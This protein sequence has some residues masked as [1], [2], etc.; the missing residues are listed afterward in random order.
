MTT[1]AQ[2]ILAIFGL[3]GVGYLAAR[4]RLLSEQVGDALAEFVFTLAIPVLL[5]RTLAK[6]DFG[7]LSPWPLWLTY[8][9]GVALTWLAA[10]V[11]IRRVFGRDARSGVVAGVSASFSNTVLVGIPLVQTLVGDQGMVVLLVILSIHLPVMMLTSIILNEWAVRADG[12]VQGAVSPGALVK[13]F[14]LNLAR[15][16]IIIG[17]VAGGLWR[18]SGLGVSGVPGRIVDSLAGVAGPLALFTAGMGLTRYGI[19][20]N[21]P[22]AGALT[23]LKLG[24]M[25]AMIMLLATL[26]DLSGP[27][28]AAAVL[29]AACPTGVNAY[30]IAT[31]FGTGQAISSNTMLMSTGFGALTT[32][33]WVM[34]LGL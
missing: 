9:G 2:I 16:P 20:R 14:V 5:F 31:R 10:H 26:L 32:A 7:G 4:T 11:L 24:L 22:Q 1:T 3:I 23:A 6:A 8:F 28:M 12:V 18:L 13:G 17:I 19:A 21:L 33:L 27:A 29:T 15:N 25:P 34:V 30:L